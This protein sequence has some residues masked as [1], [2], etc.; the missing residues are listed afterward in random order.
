MVVPFEILAVG[1]LEIP[2][3]LFV[4][5]LLGLVDRWGP[6]QQRLAPSQ[7]SPEVSH[8]LLHIVQSLVDVREVLHR[9]SSSLEPREI[10][11][12]SCE[13]KIPRDLL[14]HKVCRVVI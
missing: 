13:N 1:L 14:A 8:M 9:R 7:L 4:L 10:S 2:L 6:L 5:Q 11:M 3:L 12:L